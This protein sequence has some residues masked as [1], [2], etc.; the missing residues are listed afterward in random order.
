MNKIHSGVIDN[1]EMDRKNNGI[2]A[3]TLNRDM[4]IIRR[5]LSLSARM[6]RDEQGRPWLDTVPMLPVIQ[7]EKRKPRPISWHEQETL[8][9]ALPEYLAEMVLFA[10]NTGLRDQELCGMKWLD[11]CKVQGLDT[12]VFII[13]SERAKNEHERIKSALLLN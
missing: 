3:G 10:L 2:T 6:W 8:L 4:A 1:Y 13:N 5:V 7:G 12:T 9:K 11:E